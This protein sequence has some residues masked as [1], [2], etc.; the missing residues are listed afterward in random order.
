MEPGGGDAPF[1]C[2]SHWFLE[3]K[4]SFWSVWLKTDDE[5]KLVG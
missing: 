1:W 5:G 4:V 3:T 2:D